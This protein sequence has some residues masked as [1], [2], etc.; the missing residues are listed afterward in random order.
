M[1]RAIIE[2]NPDRTRKL[3]KT[4]I[5]PKERPNVG[6]KPHE[7]VERFNNIEQASKSVE[8]WNT[9]LKL[10]QALKKE[11]LQIDLIPDS[12]AIDP[13]KIGKEGKE[14][15]HKAMISASDEDWLAV[16]RIHNKEKWSEEKYCCATEKL[17]LRIRLNKIKNDL[18]F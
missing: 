4:I 1:I 7:I 2:I 18:E 14:L 11:Q 6:L 12:T 8:D 9:S 5:D 13:N 15:I 3:V 16:V 10:I 17:L